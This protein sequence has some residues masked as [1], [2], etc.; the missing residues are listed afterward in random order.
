VTLSHNPVILVV[1]AWG[2]VY[3]QFS[4]FR[5]REVET[6]SQ[7][8]GKEF[9]C[10][11]DKGGLPQKVVYANLYDSDELTDPPLKMML[12]ESLMG[13]DLHAYLVNKLGL[14]EGVDFIRHANDIRGG[15]RYFDIYT[16]TA[17][18]KIFDRAKER[19][20]SANTDRVRNHD[21]APRGR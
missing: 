4:E 19:G 21:G 13:A 15:A 16:D 12:M 2:Y 5:N 9:R 6:L 20:T 17:I 3:S 7:D 11:Y 8:A 1:Q 10:W 14:V 18:S